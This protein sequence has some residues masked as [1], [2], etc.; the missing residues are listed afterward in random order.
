M[1]RKLN[2]AYVVIDDP[3]EKA[4]SIPFLASG[5]LDRTGEIIYQ[6]RSARAIRLLAAGEQ[7]S[8]RIV[9][10]RQT[11]ESS[12][13]SPGLLESLDPTFE[14][15]PSPGSPWQPARAGNRPPVVG[16]E[17]RYYQPAR[18]G[19]RALYVSLPGPSDSRPGREAAA[20]FPKAAVRVEPGKTYEFSFDLLC[21]GL[22]VTP[23]IRLRFTADDPA[24]RSLTTL[25]VTAVCDATWRRLAADVTVPEGATGL[26]PEFGVSFAG[27]FAYARYMEL[28]R[29]SLKPLPQ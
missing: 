28:D 13:Y 10:T 18:E 8:R 22:Y 27:S 14:H 7:P 6:G 20:A 1:L 3:T 23:L 4:G 25:A 29:L 15:G 9:P 2:V 19:Q 24:G 16:S 12:A 21:S 26:Y 11:A 5:F 17:P